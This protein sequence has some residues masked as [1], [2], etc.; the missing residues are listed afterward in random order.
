[1]EREPVDDRSGEAGVG[2]GLTHSENGALEATATD[3]RSSRSVRTWKSSSAAARVEVGV[4]ELVEA[5]I[6][7]RSAG[8]PAPPAQIRTCAL[9][10]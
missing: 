6:R 4:A 8:C 2:E 7:G 3:A 5:E 1:M 9:S 10:R